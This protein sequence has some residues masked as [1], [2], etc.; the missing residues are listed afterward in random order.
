MQ[1]TPPGQEH[2]FPYMSHLELKLETHDVP[3]IMEG[4]W[5]CI[6]FLHSASCTQSKCTVVHRHRQRGN[7]QWFHDDV[8]KWKHFPRYWPFVQ[9]I[10]WSPVN[11]PHKGQ[12][13]GALMLSLI[14]TWINDNVQWFTDTDREAMYNGSRTPTERQ[15]AMVHGHRQRGN[16]QWFTDTDRGAMYN[17]SR[18]PTER[19]CTMVHGHRRRGNMQWFTNTDRKATYIYSGSRTLTEGQCSVVPGVMYSGYWT[20]TPRDRQ[21]IVVLRHRLLRNIT[22]SL[23]HEKWFPDTDGVTT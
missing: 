5:R 4:N 23:G 16:A 13:C 22:F 21:Y 1:I 10:H 15:Y 12:W 2:C 8:I 20:P 14:F 6:R 11:S 3:M 7:V 19:Q 17:G 18:T 9:G